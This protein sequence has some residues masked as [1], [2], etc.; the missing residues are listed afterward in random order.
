MEFPFFKKKP[1]MMGQEDVVDSN[2]ILDSGE[3]EEKTEN[4]VK[5]ELSIPS[6]WKLSVEDKY[7]FQFLNNEL[8]PLREGQL[9][10]SGLDIKQDQGSFVVTAFIRNALK[11]PISLGATSIGLLDKDENILAEKVFNLEKVEKIPAKSSRPWRF[12]FTKDELRTDELPEEGWK[13]AFDMRRQNTLDLDESWERSLTPDSKAQLVKLVETLEVPK[14]GEI[15]FVPL[16]AQVQKN[17]DLHVSLLIRNGNNKSITLKQL[18][19]I[20]EDAQGDVLAEGGFNLGNFQ[21]KGNTSKPWTFIFS[22][23]LLKKDKFELKGWKAY[24]PQPKKA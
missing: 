7:Y 1:K 3:S 22:K 4:L 17:G 20:V 14:R 16:Q 5:T 24:P 12:I 2:S 15:K 8:S 23:S 19:L 10:L 21:I 13:I 11:K 9:S 6:A 18:P